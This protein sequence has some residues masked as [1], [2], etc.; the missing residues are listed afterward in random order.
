MTNSMI[1]LL[2]LAVPLHMGC[3]RD[4]S[5]TPAEDASSKPASDIGN[6]NASALL[7]AVEAHALGVDIEP[8]AARQLGVQAAE[9]ARVWHKGDIKAYD[10]LIESWGGRFVY[11]SSDP[12][13][14]TQ[15][16]YEQQRSCWYD[17]D[18]D[19]SIVYFDS[20][21]TTVDVLGDSPNSARTFVSKQGGGMVVPSRY[22]F[23]RS[24]KDLNAEGKPVAAVEIPVITRGG[25]EF[26]IT[27]IY[28]WWP[29]RHVLLPYHS[30]V[31]GGHMPPA[32]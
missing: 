30:R 6:E 4:N 25:D 5:P 9:I 23:P 15:R 32:L 22:R 21:R 7:V 27:Y 3:Q 13:P 19:L 14:A 26:V 16:A 2:L 17:S 12:S 1:W 8:I 18:N 31:T 10:A 20:A 24:T 29:E 28:V 11:D